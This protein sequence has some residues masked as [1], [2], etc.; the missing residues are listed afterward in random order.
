MLLRARAFAYAVVFGFQFQ[1]PNT[2]FMLWPVL[3]VP[4]VGAYCV[5]GTKGFTLQIIWGCNLILEIRWGARHRTR[6]IKGCFAS[7]MH[8]RSFYL[9]LYQLCRNRRPMQTLSCTLP[10]PLL[11]GRPDVHSRREW[12]W[13]SFASMDCQLQRR[14]TSNPFPLK[15]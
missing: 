9:L 11:S 12:L 7:T 2:E 3:V 10:P 6:K 8:F 13:V 5:P 4:S 15:R 1:K 14:A